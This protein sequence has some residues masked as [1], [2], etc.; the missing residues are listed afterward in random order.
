MERLEKRI[1]QSSEFEL[2]LCL[3]YIDKIFCTWTQ[4][5]QKLN[6]LFNCI[7][8][9]HPTVKFTMNYSTTIDKLE[10]DLYCKPNITQQ[11]LHAQSCHPNVNKIS[12][13][14]QHILRF[15]RIC[16]IEEKLNNRL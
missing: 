11:Q 5:S 16:S 8:S 3:Q 9:M 14:Y 6:C 7:N 10:T 4:G 13:I 1:F 15:K 2:F 12:I